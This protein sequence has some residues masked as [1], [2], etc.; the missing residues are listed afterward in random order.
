MQPETH[1]PSISGQEQLSSPMPIGPET[2]PVLPP[3]E[4]Q[5]LV[6][7]EA[8]EQRAEAT[9]NAQHIGVPV[10][11]PVQQ[12]H[13]QQ[14]SGGT[15]NTLQ[16]PLVAADEDLIEK[17]WVDKA[18]SIIKGTTDDPHA[19]TAQVNELQREYLQKRYGKVVGSDT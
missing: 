1:Q 14:P 12:P 6:S 2:I 5:P 13:Y 11:V 18:K 17:E 19:R 4:A 10:G 3:I 9:A 16:A 15:V 7:A 8:F